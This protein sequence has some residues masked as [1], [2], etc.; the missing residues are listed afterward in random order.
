MAPSGAMSFARRLLG[1]PLFRPLGA[2]DFRLLAFAAVVSLL[3]DGFYYV[4]LAWQVYAI[5]NLP[6]AL[7]IVGVT[8]TLPMVFLLVGGAFSDRYDRRRLMIGADIVRAAG[9][10]LMAVLALTGAADR[11][12]TFLKAD[13]TLGKSVCHSL[14]ST[15]PTGKSSKERE[16]PVIASMFNLDHRLAE[17]RPSEDEQRQARELRDI[18]TRAD[19]IAQSTAQAARRRL[20]GTRT[21]SQSTRF[22]V[23]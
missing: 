22:A 13:L 20:G 3:G 21:T 15:R 2:R 11:S 18:A 23:G 12:S 10:G 6:S 8:G 17:L 1:S 7:A 19:R 9:I 4:A 5:S 14:C 16:S